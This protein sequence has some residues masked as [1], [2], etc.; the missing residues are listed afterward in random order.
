VI[1]SRDNER[2]KLIRKLHERRWRDKLGLFFVEGED[3][4]EAARVAGLEAVELLVAGEN[5]T[6]ALLAEVSTAAHPPRLIGVYR[7]ADLPP[8]APRPVRLALWRVS[9]PGN[10]GTIIRTLDAF[11]GAVYLSEGCA[12]PTGPK[13][14]RASAGSIFRVPIGRFEEAPRPWAV[15]D[16]HVSTDPPVPT[17]PREV[18]FVLGA[19]RE[20]VPRDVVDRSDSVWSIPIDSESLNVAVAASIALWEWRRSSL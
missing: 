13:A 6:A 20:G 3:A 16:P 1:V 7:R 14:V 17:F 19:E 15:L 12:D 4:V 10:L 5:V 9:D 2:L 8:P 18:T 11:R